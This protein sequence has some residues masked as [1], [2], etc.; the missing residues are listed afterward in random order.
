MYVPFVGTA[1]ASL[2]TVSW[3]PPVWEDQ[4]PSELD[5][6]VVSLE[7]LVVIPPLL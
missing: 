4:G 1:R 3:K 7:G 5:T 2:S 6:A